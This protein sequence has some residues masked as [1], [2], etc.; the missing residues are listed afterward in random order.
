MSK[1]N[2]PSYHRTAIGKKTNGEC[3]TETEFEYCLYWWDYKCC[4]CGRTY[5]LQADHWVSHKHGGT[6]AATNI[7]PMCRWCNEEKGTSPALGWLIY[8]CRNANRAKDIVKR[9]EEYFDEVGR[10]GNG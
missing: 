7:V 10:L 2:K 3:L 6:S 8:K 1:K 4:V 9:V 5:G